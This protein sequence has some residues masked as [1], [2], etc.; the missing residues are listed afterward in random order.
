M[1]HPVGGLDALR[2]LVT[3]S[4]ESALLRLARDA[5]RAS[6]VGAPRPDLGDYALPAPEI[7]GAFV[8]LHERQELRGCMGLVGVKAPLAGV[9]AEAAE[10]A[11]TR[12][13]RFSRLPLE[14]FDRSR[15]EISLMSALEPLSSEELPSALRLGVDGL[16][17]SEGAK[18]GLLLPQVATEH[19]MSAEGFLEATCRK[20]NL[21]HDA[22][23]RGATIER[24]SAI[25]LSE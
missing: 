6:L 9:V 18:R 21:P 16:V 8:S 1:N 15:I 24:F 13:P 19:G 7:F 14:A 5:A 4:V 20:A 23:R 12:D 22:W 11:A 2:A 10:S 25:V 17:V 3:G